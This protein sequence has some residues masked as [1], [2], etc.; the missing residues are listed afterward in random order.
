ME[1]D[2]DSIAQSVS[3]VT[4]AAAAP[5][6]AAPA[7]KGVSPMKERRKRENKAVFRFES[8]LVWSG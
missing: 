1:A 4:V 3:E 2:I 5:A 6:P 7:S 8:S